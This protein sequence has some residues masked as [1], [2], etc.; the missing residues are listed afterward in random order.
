MKKSK[1]FSFVAIGALFLIVSVGISYAWFSQRAALSTL[2]NITPPDSINIVPIDSDGGDAVVLD[3]DFNE[4]FGDEKDDETGNVTIRRPVYIY[5]S[6]PVH[7]LEIVHTT[8][9]NE[10]K[11]A[12]YPATKEAD[13]S[14]VY[15]K[16]N[17]LSGQYKN[18]NDSSSLAEQEKLNNYKDGDSVEVHAYPL[19][20]LADNSGDK[21]FVID[22][23]KDKIKIEVSSDR[24]KKYDPAKQVDKFYYK[25]YYYLEI[26][27]Q[28]DSKETDLFYI[29]AQNIAV[30]ANEEGS[31]STP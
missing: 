30:T 12:I 7:Q 21:D 19:Y 5:S 9:L 15:D 16:S 29:M 17:P 11:F 25:T 14:F 18:Q 10:L 4:A 8:N 2:M 3:L 6:S 26:S 24:E 20:W 22:S 31:V 23:D 28:E 13:G 1:I 27:W